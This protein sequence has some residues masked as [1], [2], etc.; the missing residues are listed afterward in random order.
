MLLHIDVIVN[1]LTSYTQLMLYL[2]TCVLEPSTLVVLCCDKLEL[3]LQ[4]LL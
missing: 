2:T 1:F 3:V 4:L